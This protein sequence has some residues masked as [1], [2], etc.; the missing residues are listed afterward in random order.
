MLCSQSII[1]SPHPAVRAIEAVAVTGPLFIILFAATYFLLS[2]TDAAN[3]SEAG[4]TRIDAFYF[5][6]TVFATV[7]FGDITATSQSARVL[8]TVQMILDL[9]VLGAVI[10]VFA[11]AVQL[12][13]G[14]PP[15]QGA[16]SSLATP[17]RDGGDP[18]P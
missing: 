9:I 2:Q 4:L 15:Q 6:V 11:G 1:R 17:L 13:R 3:F 12:A 16:T 14:N 8:V 7:G 5:T 10:R 18:S